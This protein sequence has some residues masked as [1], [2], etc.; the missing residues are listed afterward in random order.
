MEQTQITDNEVL[1][2]FL[3]GLSDNKA[4]LELLKKENLTLEQAVKLATD[5]LEEKHV[6]IYCQTT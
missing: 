5:F 6:Y 4:R 3:T 1:H 2:C